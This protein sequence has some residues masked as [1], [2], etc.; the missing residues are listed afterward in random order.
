MMTRVPLV[1]GNWKMNGTIK[2]A[3]DLVAALRPDLDQMEAVET[4]VCPPFTA[5][6]RVSESLSGSKIALG[7][8][9]LYWEASGA[10][11]GEISPLMVRELCTHVII[12]HSERRAYFFETDETVNKRISAAL[13]ADLIPILCIGETLEERQS[14]RTH[15]VVQHQLKAAIQGIT[16]KTPD[17][18]VIAYEPVWAIGT[19]KAAT[20]EDANRVISESIRSVLAESFGDRLSQSIRVLY[21]G[22]VKPENARVFFEESEI[23]GALVGGA[24]LKVEAFIQIVHA[25]QP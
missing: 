4:L 23:D 6:S 22:S 15:Q 24:S 12:G 8:Q 9:N 14:G 13:E 7:A 25:A 3:L 10:Y 20:S 18:I 5:L 16:L 19:G 21:G 1:A 11:T 17:E 2:E